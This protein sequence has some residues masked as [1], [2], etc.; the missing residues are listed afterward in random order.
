[1]AFVQV[2]AGAF[3]MRASHLRAPLTAGQLGLKTDEDEGDSPSATVICGEIG[4]RVEDCSDGEGSL[5][6][7]GVWCPRDASI[8]LFLRAQAEST[9]RDGWALR[10]YNQVIR[11][12][13]LF[14]LRNKQYG[15]GIEQVKN[16]TRL[17][18]KQG[19]H[20]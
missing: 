12:I 15:G 18:Q 2:A 10:K 16:H 5:M 11:V 19:G 4:K 7:W 17:R 1:M 14:M 20:S 3:Q 8:S 13:R 9:T 6:T